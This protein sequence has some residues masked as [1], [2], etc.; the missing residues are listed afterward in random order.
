MVVATETSGVAAE[1]SV[2]FGK[3]TTVDLTQWSFEIGLIGDDLCGSGVKAAPL[4]R[5]R[6][7]TRYVARSSSHGR[8]RNGP[9]QHV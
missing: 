1:R 5:A 6:T 7:H 2:F 4:A 8:S 3:E 9:P